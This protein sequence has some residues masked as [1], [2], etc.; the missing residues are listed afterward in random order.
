MLP[1]LDNFISFGTD[2]IKSRPDYVQMIVDMYA[3][4]IASEHLGENDRI[5]GSKLIECL[6][7]NLRGSI[8]DVSVINRAEHLI[9]IFYP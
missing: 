7:L 1:V 8:D 3:R 9:L 2:V 5:N 4:S 6:L